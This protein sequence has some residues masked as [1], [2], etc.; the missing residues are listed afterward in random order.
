MCDQNIGHQLIPTPWLQF[1][2]LRTLFLIVNFNCRL[3]LTSEEGI[4][5]VHNSSFLNILAKQMRL[6]ICETRK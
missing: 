2:N 6:K 4:N 3:R 5:L 1:D